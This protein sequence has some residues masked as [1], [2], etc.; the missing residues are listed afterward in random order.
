MSDIYEKNIDVIKNTDTLLYNK[1]KDNMDSDS[2][3]VHIDDKGV[4][5]V[6]TD[7][8][9]WALG[10]RYDSQY[11]VDRWLEQ[12]DNIHYKNV[13]IVYGLGNGEYIRALSR[14]IG[15]ENAIIV[16]E[17][18]KE[19]FIEVIKRIDI[20]DILED[21]RILI[22]VNDINGELIEEYIKFGINYELL[23]LVRV[24][25]SPN[26]FRLFKNE[27][28]EFKKNID[29]G[30]IVNLSHR[31]TNLDY[32]KEIGITK[33]VNIWELM[34]GSTIDEL[35]VVL[36]GNIDN[37]PAIIVSAGPSLDKNIDDIVRAK[38]KAFIIAVDSAIR[39]MIEH[40]IIPDVV[41]TVDSHKPMILFESDKAK[42]IPIVISGQSRHE[43]VRQHRGKRFIY[44]ANDFYRH[45]IQKWH[46]KISG[47]L[48]GGSVANDAYSLAEYLGFKT[49]IFVGQDLALTDNRK[50]ASSVYD[51]KPIENVENSKSYTYVK[52]NEGNDILTYINLKLYKEWF[53]GRIATNKELEVINATEGGARIEGT[54]V[55]TLKEA[56]KTYCKGNISVD[57]TKVQPLFNKDEMKDVYREIKNLVHECDELTVELKDGLDKYDEIT[58]C[59]N[60]GNIEKEKIEK[61][62]KE[63]DKINSDI[64]KNELMEIISLCSKPQ[65]IAISDKIYKEDDDMSVL[66]NMVDYSK[67][68]LGIYVENTEM[69]KQQ[70]KELIKNEIDVDIANGYF[71][72]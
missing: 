65:E 43:I 20:S 53:E 35:K 47:L 33:I 42:E 39:K 69:I 6:C 22:F 18:V 61:Y 63:T 51:E 67:Q 30:L 28:E 68:L 29:K 60:S 15:E 34:K 72:S 57:I 56:I 44:T 46:K 48:T 66:C 50:H 23:R 59:L 37:I 49:I 10:S 24:E 9:W 14:I 27:Y 11:A 55:M 13:F 70:I 40:N 71:E 2:C 25:S 38:G 32:G 62:V 19:I 16:Y 26:Y 17:P 36:D 64:Q 21:E 5:E 4:V 1:L 58:A 31:M 45:F 41:A 52:D 8:R 3:N 54:K 12:F 7:G